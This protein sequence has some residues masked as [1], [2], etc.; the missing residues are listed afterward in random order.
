M[1]YSESIQTR[2]LPII[3][4]CSLVWH[5]CGSTFTRRVEQTQNRAMRI[6]LQ[7]EESEEINAPMP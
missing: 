3:D 5:D 6:T 7:E 2:I 4:Y 1:F